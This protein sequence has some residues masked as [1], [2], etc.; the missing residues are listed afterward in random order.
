MVQIYSILERN[1][2]VHVSKVG[3]SKYTLTKKQQI[4]IKINTLQ[5]LSMSNII[6]ITHDERSVRERPINSFL[7][8]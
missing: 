2:G 1:K 5:V 3:T 7:C 4:R 8:D 6:T